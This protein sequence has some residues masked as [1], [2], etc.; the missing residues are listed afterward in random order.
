MPDID[1]DFSDEGR[2]RV[3]EYVKAKYGDDHVAQICTFGTMAARA[4]VKDV[5][6]ALGIPFSEMNALAK[7][8]PSKPGTKIKGALEESVEFK[9][10]YDSDPRYRKVVDSA[11][12]LEGS[13]RQLGVHACAVII[14]P[15]PMTN[16]C[17]LQHPP[18]DDKAIVTQL[19]QYP[20]EDLGL[21]K[22]DFLGLRNLTIIDRC[23]RIVRDRHGQEIDML[24]IDYE[25]PKVFR[26]F[27]EGDTT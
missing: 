25:D 7:K 21:L 24:K 1:V 19:S 5:G 13:V 3:F 22:M 15:E 27:A 11:M 20:I 12:K 17:A 14:A 18:K 16:F 4:A 9:Q 26:V 2:E 23:L 6:K 10:A 8:M